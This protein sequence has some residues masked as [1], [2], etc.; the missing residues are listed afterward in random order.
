MAE[1]SLSLNAQPINELGQFVRR[2]VDLPVGSVFGR[3]TV[4]GDER[5]ARK[6]Y[7]VTCRCDCGKEIQC[8]VDGL[9]TGKK[10][11]C[12]NHRRVV[13][14]EQRRVSGD[15]NRTHGRAG[16]TEY[17]S[18]IGMKMRCFN[19]KNDRYDSY[20]GRGVTVAPEWIEDFEAFFVHM[21]PK[22]SPSHS[23]DRIDPNGNYE[24]GNVRWA[25]R[26]TQNR[27]RRPF[28]MYPGRR[29]A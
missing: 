6:Q 25:D 15:R 14:D 5:R 23:L 28:M 21:G 18:W 22:P 4:V 20:G 24:P 16:T 11:Q 9:K 13:T 19:P 17:N 27:N 7:V 1:P 8:R 12:G 2:H 29:K 3:L 26:S 10:L